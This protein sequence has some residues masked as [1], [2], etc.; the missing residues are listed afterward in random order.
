M[1]ECWTGQSKTASSEALNPCRL[2]T[3][4]IKAKEGALPWVNL[5]LNAPW[6]AFVTAQCDTGLERQARAFLPSTQTLEAA[7]VLRWRRIICL[8]ANQAPNQPEAR[9]N[10]RF[11]YF[12]VA[13][14]RVGLCWFLYSLERIPHARIQR[15]LWSP[16]CHS[17]SLYLSLY[18]FTLFPHGDSHGMNLQRRLN[19]QC[20]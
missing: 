3:M 1:L 8:W 20:L 11:I 12:V 15:C 17:V 18:W 13:L 2:E 6:E 19:L 7:A 5:P 16:A 9:L 14:I 10:V 4:T